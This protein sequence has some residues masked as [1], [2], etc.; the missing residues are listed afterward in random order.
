MKQKPS[1]YFVYYTL[2]GYIFIVWRPKSMQE[3][4]CL[5]KSTSRNNDEK[6][7]LTVRLRRIQGQLQGIERMIEENRYCVDILI[8]VA[9]LEKGIKSFSSV[10]LKK[11]LETCVAED[12]KKGDLS[13]LEEIGELFKKF[14]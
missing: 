3:H 6:K 1:N 8:Q 7:D 4:S 2:W 13:S 10:L 9:A 5:F 14:N 11:H 12:V